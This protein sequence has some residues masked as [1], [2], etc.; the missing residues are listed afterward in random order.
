[1]KEKLN[2]SKK[3]YKK[4]K[5]KEEKNRKENKMGN[6]KSTIIWEIKPIQSVQIH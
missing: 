6:L 3:N 4:A 5:Q 1:M 2:K